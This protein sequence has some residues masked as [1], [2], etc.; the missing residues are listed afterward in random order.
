MKQKSL[1]LRGFTLIELLVVVAIIGI[2]A[3]VVMG[4]LGSARSGSRDSKRVADIKNIELAMR[5]YYLDK[6]FYPLDI[7]DASGTYPA[8]DPRNGLKDGYLP[9]VP[10]DPGYNVSSQT[11]STSP[12]TAG[13]YKFI[14]LNLTST[15][16]NVGN[17][18]SRYHIGASLENIGNNALTQ[19]TDTAAGY[20][21]FFTCSASGGGS[22][23]F[24]GL[25]AGTTCSATAGTAQPGGTETC[26]D[27]T[28]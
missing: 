1:R 3:S 10:T 14:A 23:D 21:G 11:C 26:Y 18:P 27:M 19:D 25:S 12:T 4:S 16:C 17:P 8:N 2:L 28:P 13:C 22:T 6:G 20:L 24:S 15:T 7:Y 9:S 5:L